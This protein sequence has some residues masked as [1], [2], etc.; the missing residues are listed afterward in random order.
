MIIHKDNIGSGDTVLYY[1]VLSKELEADALDNL[2]QECDWYEMLS[3][4]KP[5]SRRV[6][7]QSNIVDGWKPLYRYPTDKLLPEV[8]MTPTVK[9]IQQELNTL[10]EL[11]L[12]HVKIQ[13]YPNGNAFIGA[14]SDKTLDMKIGYPFV[15]L[16]LGCTRHMLIKS[17]HDKTLMNTCELKHNSVC[18]IGW[19]TN[20]EFTHE[21][22]KEMGTGPRI[23][24]VFRCIDTFINENGDLKG[25]GAPKNG[26]IN[27]STIED[28][29]RLRNAFGLQ[30]KKDFEW[31]NVYGD[32]FNTI[33]FRLLNKN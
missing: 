12:N 4:G 7:T 31:N 15:N 25:Q 6:C 16:S 26:N 3:S 22:P 13:Y 30:N 29:K 8:D 11:N 23:S 28:A 17:K 19:N 32:G 1:D 33:D 24:M 2:L 9:K 18:K 21:V 5:V 14:H 20:I 10:Y 27:L